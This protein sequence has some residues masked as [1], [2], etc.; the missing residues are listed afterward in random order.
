MTG[1]AQEEFSENFTMKI[2][3]HAALCL[4]IGIGSS[5][6]YAQEHHEEEE[7]S[8]IFTSQE[9]EAAGISIETVSVQSLEETLRVPAE[10]R[11][12][13]YQT[14]HVTPRIQAQV[15][16]RHV[17]LGDHTEAGQPLVTLSSVAMAEAQGELILADREWQ[18]VRSLG[19][20]AVGQSRY[21]EA[22]VA[23]Q[24]TFAKVL[25][26]GMQ[27]EQALE[28]LSS[29]DAT[30]A[31]G[32]FDLLSPIS[33]TVLTDNFVKGELVEP[34]R[35]LFEV[36]DE[37]VLWVEAGLNSSSL[38]GIEVGSP[39]RVSVDGSEWFNGSVVQ[40]HHQLDETTRTQAVRIAVANTSD[41][42]HPGQFAE[43]EIVVGPGSPQIAVPNSALTIIK[44][45][46]VVFKLEEGGEFH[47]ELVDV[48]QVIGDWSVVN[49]GIEA[50]DEIAVNGVFHLKSL[51]LKS[52]I[53]DEH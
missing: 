42:L 28:L 30:K 22:E 39:A 53:G 14:A 10:V 47:P 49:A 21:T 36:S 11:T 6:V 12:N 1:P 17:K 7:A 8:L 15:I 2:I 23:R 31:V 32:D 24:Q 19:Q 26:Y 43:A 25:A 4:L 20:K 33:G 34:G 38:T 51:L 44:G 50:G 45:F 41:R 35:V 37:S 18:R 3:K 40:L 13:A 48:G 5:A 46:P 9:L 52:S 29:G 16:N 27:K